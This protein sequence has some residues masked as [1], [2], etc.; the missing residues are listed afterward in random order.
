MIGT[1]LS[2]YRLVRK[3][4]AGTYGEVYEGVHVHDEELRVAVKVVGPALVQDARFVDALK[5]ECRQLDRMNHSNIVRF[6]ELVVND[7]GVAMVLELLR[8]QDLNHRLA[9]GAL[10]VDIAV[11]VVEAILDGLGHAHAAGVLHRDIKPGNVYW[12]DDGR[13]VLLDFGIARAA[14]GTQATKTGQ[15]VGTFDYM[16][17]E[18]MSGSGGT[19]SSDVYAVG[20]IAW[21][22]LA[23]RAACPE[24]EVARKLVWH[25][26]EGV[27][28]AAKVAVSLGCPPW[29]ADVIA[30]LAAKDPAARPADGHAA[31]GLL[32]EKRAAAGATPAAAPAARRPPP[33]T[34]LGPVPVGS[35]PP[36]SASVPPVSVP[37]VSAGRSAPPGTVMGPA[38]TPSAPPSSVRSAP[39]ATVMGPSPSSP[40]P[41][42]VPTPTLPVP[43][44]AP[45]AVAPVP[46]PASTSASPTSGGSKV[47]FVVAGALMVGGVAWWLGRS[48]S[49]PEA[50]IVDAP[51]E[52]PSVASAPS[53][54]LTTTFVYPLAAVP[55]GTYTI[56][57]P[58]TEADRRENEAQHSVT[59]TRGFSM[60]TTEVTQGQYQALMG[61]NPVVSQTDCFRLG[62]ASSPADDEPVYCVSWVDAAN[63]A[64]AA[65]AKEGLESCY[66]VSGDKVSWPKGLAC[67]GY[68]LP[69]ESEWEVA[70]RGGGSGIYAGGH[71]LGSLGWFDGNS[72][73]R[74]HP[75]GQKASN[76]Y[77]LYD[78]SGNVWEWTWDAYGDYPTGSTTDPAGAARGSYRVLRGG[79]WYDSAAGARVAVRSF[80]VPAFRNFSL[81]FRLAR[82]I[83]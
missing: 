20:L 80:L 73:G 32:R 68:R 15:M 33:S 5:R 22:L 70:A 43:A 83:P 28:D 25:M 1:Q 13:V 76:G 71:D 50:E 62:D 54:N 12:C 2:H 65:S 29:F 39:P 56:G 81:G 59:L 63:L 35:V 82:T 46:S 42:S 10:A 27:G 44:V 11:S 45:P 40:P 3:I 47:P 51:A 55:A 78:M 24:G 7:N 16:A 79:S 4:G 18:R 21:E 69:T 38:P 37:S 52:A 77:G 34:V 48:G 75:V 14:D 9:S 31:L 19:A 53:G 6:R 74:P 72:G 41:P 8:G 66:V 67:T 23:G 64:N 30:T 49:A 26:M 57:S 17:P 36:V 58:T 61:A 60:G